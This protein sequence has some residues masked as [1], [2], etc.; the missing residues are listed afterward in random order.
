[1]FVIPVVD[2]TVTKKGYGKELLF[3]SDVGYCKGVLNGD[4]ICFSDGSTASFTTVD[5]LG[6]PR[7][8]VVMYRYELMW[9]V[10][11][12]YDDLIFM[13]HAPRGGYS[14]TVLWKDGLASILKVYKSPYLGLLVLYYEDG[15]LL[16]RFDCI[17]RNTKF[18]YKYDIKISRNSIL[19]MCI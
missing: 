15:I 7:K 3:L 19:R 1:M 16:P 5:N 17:E 11:Y 2:R 14:D 8:R 18:E 9:N 10:C 13:M 12:V 4:C 6:M